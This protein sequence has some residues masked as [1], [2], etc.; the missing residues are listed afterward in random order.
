[1][2]TIKNSIKIAG[3]FVG[4]LVGAGFAS[5]QETLQFFTSFGM[6]GIAGALLSTAFFVFLAMTFTDLGYQSGSLS[7]RAVIRQICGKHLGL[8]VDGIITLCMISV[9]VVMFAGAGSVLEQQFAIPSLYGG[10]LTAL[11]TI[12][13]VSMNIRHVITFI[14]SITPALILMTVIIS[15]YAMFTRSLDIDA[16]NAIAQTQK[17]PTTHWSGSALLYVSYNIVGAAP[18][19]IILGGQSNSRSSA[20]WGGI[21]GGLTLGLLLILINLGLFSQLNEA[22][23]YSMPML[24]IAKSM[25]PTMGFIM[26]LTIYAM[27]LNTAV[28]LLYSFAAR[29]FLINT[30]T[31]TLGTVFAGILAFIASLVGFVNLV[32]TVYPVFGYLGF[33]LIIAVFAAWLRHLFKTKTNYVETTESLK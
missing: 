27:I 20:I 22:V 3:A 13:L 6:W 17:T 32:G 1:M 21:L 7:H 30:R 4:I 28:G 18:F 31:F 15:S 24:A 29:V 19:L 16:L 10:V 33:L 25:S 12:V 23:N 5:G 14:A 11:L 2:S 9:T 8:V 26:A